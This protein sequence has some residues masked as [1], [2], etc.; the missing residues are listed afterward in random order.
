MD[1]MS[2]PVIVVCCYIVGEIFKFLFKSRKETYKLIPILVSILGGILGI[3]IYLTAPE[4]IFNAKNIWVALGIGVV[5]GASSTGA[6]QAI[7]QIL[8]DKKI[9]VNEGEKKNE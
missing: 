1:Y 9:I 5:S 7:K 6:N 4:I 3:L 8:K 2:V